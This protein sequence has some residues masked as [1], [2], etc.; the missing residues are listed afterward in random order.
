MQIILLVPILKLYCQNVHIFTSTIILC[1]LASSHLCFQYLNYIA[2][3]NIGIIT[4]KYLHFN[5]HILCFG[6][7]YWI[8]SLDLQQH[9]IFAEYNTSVSN[10]QTILQLS[11]RSNFTRTNILSELVANIEYWKPVLRQCWYVNYVPTRYSY[12]ECPTVRYKWLKGS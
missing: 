7:Q 2:V 4:S 12:T 1:S 8:S 9:F 3:S 5:F 6:F 11:K 10:T